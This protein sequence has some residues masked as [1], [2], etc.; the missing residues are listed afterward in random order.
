MGFKP[1]HVD[2]FTEHVE[3]VPW[4]RRVKAALSALRFAAEDRFVLVCMCRQGRHRSVSAAV[5]LRTILEWCCIG[6]RLQDDDAHWCSALWH[7]GTCGG[8]NACRSFSAVRDEALGRAVRAW[9]WC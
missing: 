4:L 7:R 9:Q 6:S 5:V 2:F 1:E 8:C 3:F